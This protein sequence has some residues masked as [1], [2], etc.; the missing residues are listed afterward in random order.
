MGTLETTA[1]IP[2]PLANFIAGELARAIEL[3]E[4]KPGERL[5]EAD[6][7]ARY[8]VS[9]APVREA[10]RM[11]TRHE[12]V[13]Q[14]PRRGT[15]VVDLS[16][17]EISEMFELRSALYAAVVRLFVRRASPADLDSLTS[18]FQRIDDLAADPSVTPAQFVDATQA[19]SV[20]LLTQ[21]GNRRLQ[22][23]FRKLTR[24]SYRYYAEMA[25]STTANR[26]RLSA[27]AA[28]LLEAARAGDAEAA[29]LHAWRLTE[30]NHAAALAAI[31]AKADP[32]SS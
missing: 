3:G 29:S 15:V 27:F 10:L 6:I 23:T 9:R 1:R 20:F 25:H 11:L 22:E 12:L 18:L 13:T 28:Q 7:A 8:G 17:A 19:S 14:R 30:S 5:V 16:P 32:Q 4:Y 2:E 31:A 21:C 24:Q 26:R